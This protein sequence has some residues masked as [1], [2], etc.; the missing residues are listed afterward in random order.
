[1]R[2]PDFENL[3][4][5]LSRNKPARPTLFEFFLNQKLYSAL[6]GM[7]ESAGP[8]MID[9]YRWVIKAF[10]AAGYDYATVGGSK[11]G[12]PRKEV[13][14]LSTISQN[15]GSMINDRKS[16][17]AYKWPDPESFDYSPLE[18]IGKELSEGMKLIVSGPGG[19]LENVT[20]LVGYDNM[21]LMLMDDPDLLKEIFDSVGSRLLKY[22]EI[23][24][25]F[26]SVGALISNDDWGFKTQTMLAP[27]E[28]RNYVFPWHKKIVKA[29]H[30]S[31]KPAILHS[32]GNLAE[33]ID[34]VIDDMKYDGKHS[35]EDNI[36]PVE[37][38]YEKWGGRIAIL[39]GIDLDFVCSSS[40]ERV[41]ERC[42]KMIERSESKGSYGLGSGNSI[43][44]Y[45]PF[46]NY[47]AMISA[48]TGADYSKYL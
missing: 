19:V 37:Q 36:I 39:G 24:A 43:P 29:I 13:K 12:F 16:F 10:K 35:Y 31:K 6:A 2:K 3:K 28:M 42:K 18:K 15:E 33:V 45:V 32:C 1:M 7:K 17:E 8:E 46:K 9:N 38:A 41:H 48:A 20:S 14:H 22:Y 23:C 40:P 21:C 30:N 47:F 25:P 4:K 34:E 11:F 26:K 44:E 5:V 27:K